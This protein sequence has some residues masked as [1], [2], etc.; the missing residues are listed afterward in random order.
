MKSGVKIK[1]EIDPIIIS[2]DDEEV[3]VPRAGWWR[4]SMEVTSA[5]ENLKK[6]QTLVSMRIVHTILALI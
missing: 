5:M 3:S 6:S 2:S 1:E 4:W